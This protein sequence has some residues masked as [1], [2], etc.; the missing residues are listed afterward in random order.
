M[1]VSYHAKGPAHFLPFFLHNFISRKREHKRKQTALA[2]DCTQD[3]PQAISLIQSQT[4]P[5]LRSISR[6]F[7]YEPKRL[8]FPSSSALPLPKTPRDEKA[9]SSQQHSNRY[10]RSL[11]LLLFLHL[12]LMDNISLV[13]A[14]QLG[15]TRYVLVCLLK[16]IGQTPILLLV[17][18]PPITFLILGLQQK[19]KISHWCTSSSSSYHETSQSL[20]LDSLALFLLLS[21]RIGVPRHHGLVILSH[22][23]SNR[24]MKILEVLH[25]LHHATQVLLQ[26]NHNQ[27]INQDFDIFSLD[28]FVVD[29]DYAPFS[30]V[31]PAAPC[32]ERREATASFP[33]DTRADSTPSPASCPCAPTSVPHVS[34]GDSIYIYINALLFNAHGLN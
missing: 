34:A 22:V 11:L 2:Y 21:L 32:S 7:P 30:A 29:D 25:M 19:Q 17:D 27:S 15:Q 5:P 14:N 8:S 16:Q 20:L 10:L 9:N 4:A 33:V 31:S 1:N 28:A 12:L 26:E 18:Q 13:L 3:A 24:P 23:H 6:P